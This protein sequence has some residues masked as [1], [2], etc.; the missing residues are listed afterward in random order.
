MNTAIDVL[1]LSITLFVGV[2]V[3]LFGTAG[4]LLNRRRG[5]APISGII[6]GALFGP[7]GLGY[8]LWRSTR[9]QRVSATTGST[10]GA[11]TLPPPPAPPSHMVGPSPPIPPPQR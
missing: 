7:F 2:W 6:I 5:R 9:E 11:A 8:L 1:V 4:A 3:L 10:T